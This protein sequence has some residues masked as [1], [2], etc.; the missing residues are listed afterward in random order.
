MTEVYVGTFGR[1]TAIAVEA[2]G[3]R[4]IDAGLG[5]DGSLL[6]PGRAIWTLANLEALEAE[7][8]DRPDM[9]SEGFFE[10]LRRQLADTSPAVT[11]LNAELLILNVLPV[12]DV[13]GGDHKAR[14]VEKVLG[15][16]P[17]G[18]VSSGVSVPT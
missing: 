13:G 16:V 15:N 11:Q 14:Q 5:G 10:R 3:R 4:L 18:G 12:T 17:W 6:T 9:G 8:V 7:Y 2:V 1:A